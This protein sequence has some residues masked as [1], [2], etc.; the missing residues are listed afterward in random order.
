VL[1]AATDR[2][3][4]HLAGRAIISSAHKPVG[5]RLVYGR[6]WPLAHLREVVWI[7]G[8]LGEAEYLR[9]YYLK[10]WDEM[11]RVRTVTALGKDGA[12]SYGG[13]LAAALTDISPSVR[14]SAAIA[15]AATVSGPPPTRRRN[16]SNAAPVTA[17]QARDSLE[18]LR[19]DPHPSVRM[20]ANAALR[21]LG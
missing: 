5:D 12:R 18:P 14:A 2:R 4:L 11:V 6:R 3:I 17:D 7:L 1:A 20:A 13:D 15:L 8:E 9:P 19:N 21:R 10:H 16:I